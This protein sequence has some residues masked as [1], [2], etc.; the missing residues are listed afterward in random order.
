MARLDPLGWLAPELEDLRQH[1]LLRTAA[2]FDGP[3][4]PEVAHQGRRYVL[5]AS[6]NY[7]GLAADVRVLN[8]ASDALRR[9]GASTTASR[10]ISGS[11]PLHRELE[12]ELAAWKGTEAAILFSSGY[13]ANLGTI[14]ALAG[15]G[16]VIFCDRLNHA[17]IIDAAFLSRARLIVYQHAD[18]EHLADLMERYP[19]RRRLIV[20][21]SVFSMDG[22]LAPLPELCD[23]AD[24]WGAMLMVDEAH[25]TGVIGPRGAGAVAHFGLRGEVPIVMGTLSK[26]LGSV[27]GFVAGSRRLV[28]YLRNRARTFIFDTALPPSA[29]G[30]ALAAMR[31]ARVDEERRERLRR[32]TAV[33]WEELAAQ[34]YD[35]LPADA[36]II[37]IMVGNSEVALR[38]A[39]AL[40]ERGVW[41]PA[42]RPPS[43]PRGAARLRV[44]LMAT[45]TEV[46][47]ERAIGAFASARRVLR[48]LESR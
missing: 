19:G 10:L 11:T 9:F 36:A 46:H 8:A 2:E 33:L 48:E 7:L 41:V 23:V 32:L 17:S 38:L 35:L 15:P 27:G 43:V 12:A 39:A 18:P 21:D 16:D 13:L 25:A 40:R 24:H 20:T 28:E 6:N 47:L 44:S 30:A 14:G 4:E 1:H 37:P 42:I 34:G 29:V 45:H 3:P 5:F 22:D 26:A 31:I